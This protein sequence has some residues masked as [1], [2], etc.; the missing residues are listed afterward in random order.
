MLTSA[1][2]LCGQ[3]WLESSDSEKVSCFFHGCEKLSYKEN[4]VFDFWV[5]SKFHIEY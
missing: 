2:Q 4:S 1:A 5:S 3:A